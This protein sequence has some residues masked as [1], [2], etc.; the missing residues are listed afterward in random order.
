MAWM[1]YIREA[2][3]LIILVLFSLTGFIAIFF[4]TFGTLII[5][6]GSLIYAVM[7]KFNVLTAGDLIILFVLYF[8]GELSEYIFII[9]GGKKLGASN[10]AIIGALIGGI[11]G[12]TFGVALFGVGI[13]LGTFLGIFLGAFFVELASKKS[14]TRSFKAGTGG[15]LNRRSIGPG[16]L[17]SS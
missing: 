16:R 8:C 10:K 2:L 13:I 11:L 6:I 12:A 9:I 15:V 1:S 17:N 4:T 3:A 5:M 14:F 7:T